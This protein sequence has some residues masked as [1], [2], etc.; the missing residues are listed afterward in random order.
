[1]VE[2][3]FRIVQQIFRDVVGPPATAEI[4]EEGALRSA[5]IIIDILHRIETRTTHPID[6][7]RATIA[8]SQLIE[9]WYQLRQRLVLGSISTINDEETIRTLKERYAGGNLTKEDMM[10]RTKMTWVA[11]PAVG[12]NKALEVLST[13]R[14]LYPTIPLRQQET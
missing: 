4:S 3:D 2:K 6:L 14:T 10:Q 11:N 12:A 1:M 8:T 13:L 7:L 9:R 5:G